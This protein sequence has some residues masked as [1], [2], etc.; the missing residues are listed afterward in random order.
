MIDRFEELL[1]RELPL[2]P[3]GEGAWNYYLNVILALRGT[4]RGDG[5]GAA[6]AANWLSFVCPSGKD[7]P[8]DPYW[9]ASSQFSPN[10]LRE[11]QD[12]PVERTR[13]SYTAGSALSLVVRR[14]WRG[15]VA[16]R[17]SDVSRFQ[18]ARVV[19]D[20][21]WAEL[22]WQVEKG[23]V[24]LETLPDQGSWG[25]LRRRAFGE[26][27]ELFRGATARLLPYF[28]CTYPHRTSALLSG[29][30]DWLTSPETGRADW[31]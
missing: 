9:T 31:D 24:E 20:E 10:K 29:E 19:P 25:G 27:H 6:M 23:R 22:D 14:M 8:K 1:L 12:N 7:R 16:T 26:R 11:E 28:L 5:L 13:M 3:W 4:V 21:A 30:L 2:A 15:L 17:W 18:L